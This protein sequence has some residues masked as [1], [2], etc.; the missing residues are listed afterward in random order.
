[1]C[2]CV[3]VNNSYPEK[4]YSSVEE[5]LIVCA[6]TLFLNKQQKKED[7]YGSVCK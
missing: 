2:M 6:H 7:D 4:G 5:P 1:M 3:C